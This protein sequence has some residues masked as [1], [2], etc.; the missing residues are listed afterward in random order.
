MKKSVR[1]L[2]F[3]LTLCAMSIHVIGGE[4]D[5]IL[6]M[7]NGK[8]MKITTKSDEQVIELNH[9]SNRPVPALA[10]YDN[11][12]FVAKD[13]NVVGRLQQETYVYRCQF[14]QDKLECPEKPFHQMDRAIKAVTSTVVIEDGLYVGHNHGEIY[15]CHVF[16]GNCF[17]IKVLDGKI[18]GLAYDSENDKIYDAQ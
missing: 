3:V 1:N 10:R 15:H 13:N 11:Y 8:V 17:E 12:V 4:F 9:F 18:T 6:G 2:S 14:E 5:V 16:D 7:N